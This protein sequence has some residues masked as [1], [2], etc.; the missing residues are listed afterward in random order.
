MSGA[1][2]SGKVIVP[3]NTLALFSTQTDDIGVDSIS[4]IIEIKN[5][6]KLKRLSCAGL[7]FFFNLEESHGLNSVINY[8]NNLQVFGGRFELTQL[9]NNMVNIPYIYLQTTNRNNY[10]NID[11]LGNC[12]YIY[13]FDTNATGEPGNQVTQLTETTALNTKLESVLLRFRG[14]IVNLPINIKGFVANGSS[15]TGSIESYITR[16]RSLGRTYGSLALQSAKNNNQVTFNGTSIVTQFNNNTLP[17]DT[18]NRC[19]YLTWTADTIEFVATK[20]AELEGIFPTP[21]PYIF[22]PE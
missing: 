6:Y 13:N 18:T 3:A 7:P 5:I 1:V 22:S 2:V 14:D 21:S 4:K 12:R 15:L 19:A 8:D 17:Y 16:V 10:F 11:N 20:P 9:P